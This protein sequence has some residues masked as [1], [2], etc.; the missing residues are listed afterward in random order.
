M[1][2]ASIKSRL[3]ES[4]VNYFSTRASDS[5]VTILGSTG[6]AIFS[7]FETLLLLMLFLGFTVLYRQIYSKNRSQSEQR[8]VGTVFLVGAWVRT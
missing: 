5:N 8:F 1:I 3:I 6:F 7:I 4:L 2:L